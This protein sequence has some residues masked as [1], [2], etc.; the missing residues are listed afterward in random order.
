[1]NVSKESIKLIK[2]FSEAYGASGQ[3][4][5]V[6]KLMRNY[7]EKYTDE[8]IYDNLG[9]IYGI[10]RTNVKDPLKVMICAH[11]DEVALNVTEINQQGLIK[12]KATSIWEQILM[13]QRV[14]LINQNNEKFKGAICAIPPH[15]LPASIKEKPVEVKN[16]VADFG[17]K[18][19][20]DVLNHNIKLGD[21]IYV[22]GKFEK[23]NNNRILAKALD[24]RI[25]C[26]LIVD[27]LKNIQNVD[28]GYELY[29]GLNVQEEVG[30]RGATTTTQMI[31][32]DFAIVV[33]CS[34]ANDL[35]NKSELGHLGEGLLIRVV[36]GAMIAFPQL[37]DWQLNICK[38]YKIPYQYF[39]SNGGTDAG[40]IHKLNQGCLTLTSCL[41]ARN[42]HSNSTILDLND[43]AANL[44]FLK[45]A[46]RKLTKEEYQKLLEAG[47]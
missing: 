25:G 9:S 3:E 33:D 45:H 44:K 4:V 42:I 46:V 47:R 12:F 34:P 18:D 7:L 17:F 16:M 2:K 24:D 19:K 27:L 30:L 39:I 8:I 26:A 38:K 21:K 10:K 11:S 1:M 6:T 31:K 14:V 29:I 23:L 35:L 41:C 37:I 28:L 5:E 32:P 13:A 36:D 20:Q 43:Y 15:L 22:E 40:Q